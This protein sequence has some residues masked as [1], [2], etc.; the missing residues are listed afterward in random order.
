ME[1]KVLYRPSYSLLRMNLELGEAVC[2]EAGAMVSMSSSIEMETKAKGGIFGALKRSVLGVSCDWT[3][4][5]MRTGLP[6]SLNA[7]KSWPARALWRWWITA[8]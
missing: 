5:R 8:T 7:K 4:T 1:Y 2:A 3:P 6:T